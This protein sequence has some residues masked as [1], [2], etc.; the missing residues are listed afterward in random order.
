MNNS[1]LA[2][3]LV[4]KPMKVTV[5]N[6]TVDQWFQNLQNQQLQYRIGH[7]F[8]ITYSRVVLCHFVHNH[9][10]QSICHSGTATDCG[11]GLGGHVPPAL[12]P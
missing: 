9:S 10:D 6:I 12:P 8:W 1:K 2:L 5:Y 4:S 3:I 11:E 7:H